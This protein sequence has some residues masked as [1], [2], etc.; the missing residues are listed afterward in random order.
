VG[1][2]DFT[3]LGRIMPHPVY[4]KINWGCVLNPSAETFEVFQ[5]LIAEDHDLAVRKRSKVQ[6]QDEAQP[7][8]ATNRGTT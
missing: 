6:S 5:H 8:T 4:G 3:A 2:P 1:A 7:G